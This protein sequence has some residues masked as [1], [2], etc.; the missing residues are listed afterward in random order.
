MIGKA[1]LAFGMHAIGEPLWCFTACRSEQPLQTAFGQEFGQA[2][3]DAQDDSLNGFHFTVLGDISVSGD[4][5]VSTRL[6]A[7]G[8]VRIQNRLRMA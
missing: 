6:P 2:L 7:V 8:E 1:D 3:D 5:R 4:A